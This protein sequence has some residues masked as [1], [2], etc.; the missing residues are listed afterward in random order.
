MDKPLNKFVDHTILKAFAGVNEITKLCDEAKKYDFASVCVNPSNVPLAKKLLAATD[1]KVCTVIGFPLGA[2]TTAIK[3][4]ETADAYANGCDEFD[5]VIN[6]G[7]LK[8]KRD[9]VVLADIQ[10]VVAEAKGKCV[11]VIIETFFLNDEEKARAVELSCQA[12]ATFVKTCTGFNDGV[13]TVADVA[14]MKKTARGRAKVKAS[15][16]IRTYADAKSLIDAGAERLGTS[17]G[18]KIL[19]EFEQG[20]K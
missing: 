1:V 10:A 16:G 6:V 12:G 9:D 4:A 5:M 15:S 8:D 13:A 14:L 17:A 3:A 11:K 20:N 19:A 2:N 18:A 7:A